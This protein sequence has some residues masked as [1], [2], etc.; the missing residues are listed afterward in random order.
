MLVDTHCHLTDERLSSQIE[1]VLA[2]A[3]ANGIDKIIVPSTGIIDGKK[4]VELSEKH[5]QVW[6][7]VGVHPEVLEDENKLAN[8]DEWLASEG[9][10]IE[11]LAVLARSSTRVVGVG[12]IGL[13]FHYDVQ[14]R[15]RELQLEIF[16]KQLELA[17]NLN[18][19]VVIHMRDA[20]EE[21]KEILQKIT[22]LPAGQFHC[23]AGSEELLERVL[24]RGFYVS[25]CG[26]ITYKSAENLMEL[27]KKVPLDRL[28]LETDSPYLAPEP[29]RSSLNE[30]I[31]VTIM[32]EYI[33]NLIGLPTETLI[34]QTTKNAE[35]LYF[36]G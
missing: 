22:I 10:W 18:L 5:R 34:N 8:R 12:E 31:N 20:E 30:P 4:A 11:K 14:K 28:L 23:W 16:S 2:R 27:V 25:F 36:P 26:N 35:C 29:V 9:N 24:Q 13:D 33:A 1:G 15:S 7:M 3:S 21:M 19:P 6:A 17:V 32:A